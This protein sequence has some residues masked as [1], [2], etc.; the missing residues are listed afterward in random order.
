MESFLH[1]FEKFKFNDE[2][3]E[4]VFIE[5]GRTPDTVCAAL[6]QRLDILDGQSGHSIARN[7]EAQRLTRLAL[8][9]LISILA[10]HADIAND[11]VEELF[12]AATR[13]EYDTTPAAPTWKYP[14]I[15]EA[16]SRL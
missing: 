5:E 14:I 12:K 3:F 15:N 1:L 10:E 4:R 11:E 16:P 9:R 8:T 6:T 7:P 2:A 13:A